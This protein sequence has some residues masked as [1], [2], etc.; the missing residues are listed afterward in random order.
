MSVTRAGVRGV[1]QIVLS[2]SSLVNQV[3]MVVSR[4]AD[5]SPVVMAALGPKA[6]E[7]AGAV[8]DAA[9]SWHCPPA[10]LDEVARP[11]LARGAASA[12]RDI[13][14]IV[15]QVAVAVTDDRGG[16]GVGASTPGPVREV[17]G[18]RDHVRRGGVSTGRR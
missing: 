3:S 2:G 12:G 15:A 14:P 16:S 5:S 4:W 10:Y 6:F 11:A 17:A 1:G 18:V 8:A 7:A 13:P 9:M